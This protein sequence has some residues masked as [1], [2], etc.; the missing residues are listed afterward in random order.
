MKFKLMDT[1]DLRTALEGQKDILS[2]ISKEEDDFYQQC[3]C[4]WCKA[5]RGRKEFSLELAMTPS[6]VPRHNLRCTACSCL[7]SPFTGVVVELGR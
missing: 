3:L 2:L 1:D 6:L 7:W 5:G 4:P